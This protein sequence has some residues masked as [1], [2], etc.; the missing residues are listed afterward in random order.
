MV[1]V[2]ALWQGLNIAKYRGLKDIVVIG[3]SRLVI[4]ALNSSNLPEDMKI[5]Q[6]IKKIQSMSSFFQNFEAFHVLRS[7]NALA[8]NTAS[9]LA[10]GT[11]DLNGCKTWSTI[12]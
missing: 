9:S 1:E 7:K 10:R 2:L 8:A 6:L 5:R 3:D 11:L 12:P 4:Q